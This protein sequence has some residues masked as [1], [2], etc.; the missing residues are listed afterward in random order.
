MGKTTLIRSVFGLTPARKGVIRYRGEEIQ[1]LAPYR[2]AKLGL[3]LV[4]QGRRI[5]KNL[6]VMENLRLPSSFLAARRAPAGGQQPD[7]WSFDTVLDEFPQLK[8]RLANGGNELSGGEQQMLAIA[9]ALI[10]NPDLILMDEPSEGLSPLF[11]QHVGQIMRRVKQLG[12]CDPAGRAE[13]QARAVGG[14]LRPHHF[15][16]PVRLLRHAGRAGRQAGRARRASWRLRREES[17]LTPD[18]DRDFACITSSCPLPAPVHWGYL[19]AAMP[20]VLQIRSG[21]TVVRRHRLRGDPWNCPVDH[22]S[23]RFTWR[24]STARS[25]GRGR[26]SSPGRSTSKAP[27]RAT[28]SKIRILE[29]ELTEDWGWNV[30]RPLRGTLPEDFPV[31][32]KRII[33]IDRSAGS[34]GC[35][36]DPR[37]RCVPS[38]AYRRRATPRLRAGLHR[39]AA[40][41]RRQRRQQGA[42]RGRSLFLPVFVPGAKLSIGRRPRGTG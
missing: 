25:R 42:G 12:A 17:S 23:A 11:V 24:S 7:A 38:S 3:S 10:V 21:D 27:C 31:L 2:I 36:G 4:P 6:S 37:F 20:T 39:R 14:R 30:I 15:L 19:D 18:P 32:S 9:R 16:G 34:P 22:L 26:T 5:F 33:P 8:E 29:V 35:R 41:V 13:S 40:R 1:A 28:P